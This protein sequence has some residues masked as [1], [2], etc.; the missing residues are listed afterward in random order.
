MLGV[1]LAFLSVQHGL[2]AGRKR[3]GVF[4][5]CVTV[6]RV[7][8]GP[9]AITGSAVVLGFRVG[10]MRAPLHVLVVVLYSAYSGVFM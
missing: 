1:I 6:S 5:R 2:L 9:L 3:F 7:T 10:A 8:S 4:W